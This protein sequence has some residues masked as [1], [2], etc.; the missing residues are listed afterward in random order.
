VYLVVRQRLARH[1][2]NDSQAAEE[3]SAFD[4]FRALVETLEVDV[5]G[6]GGG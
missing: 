2:E 6:A 1:E 3:N 4:L 5:R